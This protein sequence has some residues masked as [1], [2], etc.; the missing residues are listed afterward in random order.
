MRKILL[1]LLFGALMIAFSACSPA[2]ENLPV[3]EETP[4][5][6][7]IG[8]EVPNPMEE[9]SGLNFDE[10]LGFSIVGWPSDYAPGHTFVIAGAVAEVNFLDSGNAVVFRIAKEAEG[11]ISGVYDA[12]VSN[13]TSDISGIGV[14]MAYTTDENGLASWTKDGYTFSLYMKSGASFE[15]LNKIT[16]K[17]I[18]SISVGPR[19]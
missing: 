13:D 8:T 19:K 16:K 7:A 9:V 18:D 4:T 6:G 12:F 3:P 10:K 14:N 2:R 17:I 15:A 11:D 1:V 5:N